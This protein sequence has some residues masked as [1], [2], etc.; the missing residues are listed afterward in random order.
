MFI[1]LR[2]T[3]FICIFWLSAF[4]ICITMRSN[5]HTRQV[6][7]E[8]SNWPNIGSHTFEK[9]YSPVNLGL[10]CHGGRTSLGHWI[11]ERFF[12]CYKKLALFA[13]TTGLK[14][15]N[16]TSRKKKPPP[17]KNK[18]KKQSIYAKFIFHTPVIIWFILYETNKYL[19]LYLVR[20]FKIYIKRYWIVTEIAL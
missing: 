12:R 6:R 4:L 17:E 18:T 10:F 9:S 2:G 15:N 16:H 7:A 20:Y 1:V 3:T 5:L 8:T 14:T 19:I 13:Q 11:C